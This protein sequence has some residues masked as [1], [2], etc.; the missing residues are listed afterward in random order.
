MTIPLNLNRFIE[1]QENNFLK[2][3]KET[4]SGQKLGHW[5]WYIFPQ[6]AGLGKSET[7]ARF[8]IKNLT[9][10][11]QFVD[12]PILG[13]R[14][15]EIA[16]GLLQVEGRSTSEIFGHPDDLKL[17]SCMTLF[18]CVPEPDPVFEAILEKYF[19]GKKDLQTIW[20]LGSLSAGNVAA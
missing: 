2:A 8:A 9:E 19:E 14:L 18:S 5:M 17:H 6:I 13:V 20:L 1:A 3:L 10:A 16:N 15:I 7:A 11:K 12:H 4:R